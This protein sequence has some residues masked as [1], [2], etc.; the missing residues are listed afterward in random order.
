MP[1]D[2]EYSRGVKS[3]LLSIAHRK[4]EHD[5][6]IAENPS[7]IDPTSQQEFVT[8]GN[9]D[10]HG[11]SGN[12]ASTSFDLGLEPK[13]VGGEMTVKKVNKRRQKK[14]IDALQGTLPITATS[15][16]VVSKPKRVRVKKVPEA[17]DYPLQGG[18]ALPERAAKEVPITPGSGKGEE[19]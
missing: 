10:L 6:A 3:K 18:N 5:K 13:M 1:F 8:V 9:P 15:V 7:G 16:T 4:A 12:L 19:S 14:L 2:S 17:K 11:G